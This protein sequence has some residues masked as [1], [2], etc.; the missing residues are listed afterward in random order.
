M[1]IKL[2]ILLS[3]VFLFHGCS[4]QE[5]FVITNETKSD[6]IIEYDV[7]MPSNG[8]PIFDNHPNYY[9]LNSDGLIYWDKVKKI[10][11]LDTANHSVKFILLPNNGL[12][13]GTLSNDNYKSYDQY[14]INGRHFN[15]KDLKIKKAGTVTEIRPKNFDDYFTNQKGLIIYRIKQ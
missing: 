4:W 3:I 1:K 5:S 15:L 10:V 7:E 9:E 12:I 13:I 8:F 14:F 11:D 6:I 2:L